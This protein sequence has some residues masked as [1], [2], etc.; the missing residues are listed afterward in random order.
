[1]LCSF[2][3]LASVSTA[4]FVLI[5]ASMLSEVSLV[6]S[7]LSAKLSCALTKLSL[8]DLKLLAL[9]SALCA[10]CATCK[11]AIVII[12][13]D[14]ADVGKGR[15]FFIVLLS[16]VHILLEDLRKLL[17]VSA[18]ENI[19]RKSC[20]CSGD[21]VKSD[22]LKLLCVTVVLVY[23]AL[24][25]S[26][27]NIGIL[28]KSLCCRKAFG[29][30]LE[31]TSLVFS[32]VCKSVELLFLCLSKCVF[33]IC[34]CKLLAEV[35]YYL[36]V[37]LNLLCKTACAETGERGEC[38]EHAKARCLVCRDTKDLIALGIAV[39]ISN[40]GIFRNVSICTGSRSCA[41]ASGNIVDNKLGIGNFFNSSDK[42]IRI[43]NLGSGVILGDKI[44]LTANDYSFSAIKCLSSILSISAILCLGIAGNQYSICKLSGA[45]KLCYAILGHGIKSFGYLN[46]DISRSKSS[47]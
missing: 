32:A 13:I 2:T 19:V 47:Q 21:G 24:E 23:V 45:I 1:M 42:R 16:L 37:I 12:I 41:L 38:S 6:L 3:E 18:C 36:I 25:I 20:G 39:R 7:E 33:F 44:A 17:N 43:D 11:V 4:H 9:A 5:V 15:F 28:A 26:L 30:E 14:L 40:V 27:T 46:V 22:L 29:I 31:N 35:S 34:L 10:Y 8:A